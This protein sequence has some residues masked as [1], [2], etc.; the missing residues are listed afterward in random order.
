MRRLIGMPVLTTA[1]LATIVDD[2]RAY[3]DAVPGLTAAQR[4]EVLDT[5]D[6]TAR[7]HE[8]NTS[9]GHSTAERVR[10]CNPRSALRRFLS[11]NIPACLSL[12]PSSALWQ[13]LHIETMRRSPRLEDKRESCAIW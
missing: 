1:F 7:S 5:V 8:G 13:P 4:Q 6:T 11:K 3:V 12:R 9:T 10:G 2:T